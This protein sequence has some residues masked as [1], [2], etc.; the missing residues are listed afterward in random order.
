MRSYTAEGAVSR[1]NKIGT[2]KNGMDMLKLLVKEELK[3]IRTQYSYLQT[4]FIGTSNQILTSK[5]IS[6]FKGA[7]Q[8][9]FL[10][11]LSF[12]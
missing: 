10:V 6:R 11:G 8:P 7:V 1:G 9:I 12:L 2:Q 3:F 5:F 4:I